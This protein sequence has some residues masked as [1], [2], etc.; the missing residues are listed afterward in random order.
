MLTE[1]GWFD[2]PVYSYS[3]DTPWHSACT[4]ACALAWPA[5]LTS[6]AAGLSNWLSPWSMGR[7]R[8][9]AGTQVSYHGKPLYL[10]GGEGITISAGGFEATGSG[11]GLSVAGGTF[12]LVS[13]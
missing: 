12:T 5:V 13:P 4:G 2:F 11:N 9:P 10:Y 3:K 1:A 7:V 8:T 6:G